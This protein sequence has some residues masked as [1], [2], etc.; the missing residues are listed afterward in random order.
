MAYLEGIPVPAPVI[1][2]KAFWEYAKQ[3]ELRIQRCNRCWT[4]RFPPSPLCYKC[5][6]LDFEWVRSR[7]EGRVYSYIIVHHP[8]HSALREQVPFN[9]AVVELDDCGQIR[10]TSNIV[11]CPE[12]EVRVGM[13][14]ELVWEEV[15]PEINLYRFRTRKV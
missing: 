2:T 10:V 15:T 3:Q 6:S 8:P 12:E 4:F 5:H 14:V 7:G 1:D 9:V 13:P 11:D